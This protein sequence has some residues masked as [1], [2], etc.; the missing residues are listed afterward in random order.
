[1]NTNVRHALAELGISNRV[2]L[3]GVVH[4]SIE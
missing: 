4:R 3:T 2:A 1:V